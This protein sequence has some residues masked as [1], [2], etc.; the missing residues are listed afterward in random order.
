[1]NAHAFSLI[2]SVHNDPGTLTR[3]SAQILP[4]TQLHCTRPRLSIRLITMRARLLVLLPKIHPHQT[5]HASSI[6]ELVQTL[7]GHLGP[8]LCPKYTALDKNTLIR[9]F[10]EY[11]RSIQWRTLLKPLVIERNGYLDPC[12][13]QKCY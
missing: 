6:P 4:P 2:S 10:A 13:C 7:R 9:A 1:M 11:T 3:A 5:V 8:G 12:L